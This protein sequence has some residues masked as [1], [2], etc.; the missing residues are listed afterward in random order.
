VIYQTTELLDKI[1]KL[2]AERNNRDSILLVGKKEHSE[3]LYWYNS[4][5]FI[6]SASHY[7]GSGIAVCEG[8]S[9]GCIPLLTNIPSFRKITSN[10][11]C[12]VLYD[13]DEADGLFNALTQTQ[14]LNIEAEKEK[15]LKQ[16]DED[17][18]FNAIAKQIA[19]KIDTL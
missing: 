18:S 2:L 6:I 4:A 12:G 15:V 3:M 10:G 16:F 17:L 1:K 14:F 5:D 19:E 9:C 7:E 8:M 13:I 11:N